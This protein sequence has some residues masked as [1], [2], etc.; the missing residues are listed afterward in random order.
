ME[1]NKDALA[2]RDKGRVEEAQKA[3]RD[4][5]SFLQENA[6]RY[7]S[8]RLDDYSKSN[9]DDAGNLKNDKWQE[10]RKKMKKKAYELDSQQSY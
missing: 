6:R 3:L 9:D 1:R 2:L 4:N 8:Q 5:A 7:S 10:Q